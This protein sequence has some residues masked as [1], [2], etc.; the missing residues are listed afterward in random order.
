[1]A[2]CLIPELVQINEKKE[3]LVVEKEDQK[4]RIN[5]FIRCWYIIWSHRFK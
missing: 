2:H 1:M 3:K 5:S 4:E